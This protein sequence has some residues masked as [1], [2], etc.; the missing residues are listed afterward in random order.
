MLFLI[1]EEFRKVKTSEHYKTI[2]SVCGQDNSTAVNQPSTSS[3]QPSTS[4]NQ[5]STSGVKQSPVKSG[6]SSSIL[7]NPKQ[8]CIYCLFKIKYKQIISYSFYTYREA[9]RCLNQS[10]MYHGSIQIVSY[11][12]M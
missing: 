2:N 7:V 11:Q 12:T 6:N 8:V 10:L 1:I 4:S 3:N 9:I 5:P